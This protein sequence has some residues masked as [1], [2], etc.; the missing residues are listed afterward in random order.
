M[1]I[2]I[3]LSWSYPTPIQPDLTYQTGIVTLYTGSLT[4]SGVYTLNYNFAMTTSSLNGSLGIVGLDYRQNNKRHGFRMNIASMNNS[5]MQ[6]Y[7]EA[8]YN[9][10]P[11]YLMKVSY[12][13]SYSPYLDVNYISYSYC[14]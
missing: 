3:S 12:L 8:N 5:A 10:E 4:G 1:L 2:Q 9:R 14:N 6:V 11:I 13:A 7:L